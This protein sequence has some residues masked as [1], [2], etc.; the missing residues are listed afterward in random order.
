ML[1]TKINKRHQGVTLESID[2]KL[3]LVLELVDENTKDI[4][5][6]KNDMVVMKEDIDI[7]KE[8]IVVIKEDIEIIKQ[9]LKKKVGIDEFAALERRVSMLENRSR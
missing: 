2:S 8:D 9:D 5:L 6:I 1:K 3:D 4:T 7:V